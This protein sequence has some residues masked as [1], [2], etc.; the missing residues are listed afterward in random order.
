MMPSFQEGYY[1]AK[2]TKWGLSK[3]KNTGNSQVIFSFVPTGR[4]EKGELV[5]CPSYERSIFRVITENT[6]DFLVTD[7]KNL[8][9]T[10]DTFDALDPAHPQAF[11]FEGIEV[12]VRCV[13]EDY[14]GETKEKWQF[15]WGQEIKPLERK[16]VSQLNAMFGSRLKAAG[17]AAAAPAKTNGRPAARPVASAARAT[18]EQAE[19]VF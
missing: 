13:H 6:I 14:K 18:E 1:L 12:K 7:L 17:A 16:E 9:Y 5:D 19:E 10:P 3:N 2:I 15:A 4:E 11:N 8:G